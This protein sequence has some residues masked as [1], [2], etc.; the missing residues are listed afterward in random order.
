MSLISV[1]SNTRLCGALRAMVVDDDGIQ[2]LYV[3]V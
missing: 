2:R 1:S 3:K